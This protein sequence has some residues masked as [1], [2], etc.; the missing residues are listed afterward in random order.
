MQSSELE[1]QKCGIDKYKWKVE[2][3]QGVLSD[4]PETGGVLKKQSLL[5]D[6]VP[7]AAC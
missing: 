7:D 1:V 6:W 2:P 3:Y 4:D 5:A